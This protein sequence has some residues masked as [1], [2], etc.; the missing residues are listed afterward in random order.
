MKFNNKFEKKVW[1]CYQ[2][3]G[4]MYQIVV[5]DNGIGIDEV[6][7]FKVFQIFYC[8][9]KNKYKG[10]GLGLVICQKIVVCYCGKIELEFVFGEGICF[11]V[12]LLK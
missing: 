11:L 12:Y 5:E 2:D 6:F 8:L 3:K 9:E 1:I 7:K 10:I 4:D